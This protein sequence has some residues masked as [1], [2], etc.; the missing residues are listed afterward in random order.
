MKTNKGILSFL[1][2]LLILSAAVQ[3]FALGTPKL[4]SAYLKPDVTVKVG[5]Q[6]KSFYD[7]NGRPVYPIIYQGTTYLP[8]RAVSELMGEPIEWENGNKTIYIGRT[9]NN[10]NK[11]IVS[12]T[13]GVY[14]KNGSVPAGARPQPQM[15]SV[16][17]KPDVSVMYDFE[18]QTFF[19]A[20]GLFVYPIIYQ[21]ST[22]LPIRAVAG[23]MGEQ[24]F[25]D[26]GEKL[27]TI[28]D[29]KAEQAEEEERIRSERAEELKDAF[30]EMVSLYDEATAKIT[31]IQNATTA[32][33]LS[34]LA[35]AVSED[36]KSAS[37]MVSEVEGMRTSGFTPGEKEAYNAL[38]AFVQ[39][40]E[41]YILVLENIAYMASTG[42]D[43]SIFAE[44]FLDLAL[45][46]QA[47]MEAARQAIRAL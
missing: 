42:Q 24:I 38:L 31:N 33:E 19:D 17:L 27:I 20:Q 1:V 45:D 40:S 29:S 7:V 46:S 8:V 16:Y 4:V 41:H 21:G 3:A 5:G 18:L 36:S 34:A 13:Q 47:K 15:I 30:N 28:T 10:P 35:A 22:Y 9:L 32:E 14:V 39:I 25:W 43:Y 23:L 37:Y 2:I 11:T 6:A 12:V 26:Q 44:T